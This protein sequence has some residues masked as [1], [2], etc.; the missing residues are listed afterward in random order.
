ME[1]FETSNAA[2]GSGQ[3]VWANVSQEITA[4]ELQDFVTDNLSRIDRNNNG[5]LSKSELKTARRQEGW[6]A[7]EQATL[8]T[9]ITNYS[10]MA[11]SDAQ[12]RRWEAEISIPSIARYAEV[13]NSLTTESTQIQTALQYGRDNFSTLD[14]NQDGFINIVELSKAN[15]NPQT[16]K[17]MSNY[18]GIQSASNDEWGPENDGITRKDL[19]KFQ[20]SW[21][22]EIHTTKKAGCG[23]GMCLALGGGY[24]LQRKD[25][26][27]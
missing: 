24:S 10:I 17:L 2:A 22:S 1:N 7:R 8:D 6:S 5:F 21:L 23:C 3:S 12:Y 27:K 18:N 15:K 13:R 16:K 19:D 4:N 20:E 9:M 11:R 25:F 26:L 14:I